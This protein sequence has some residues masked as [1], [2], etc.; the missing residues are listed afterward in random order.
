MEI[1]DV[2][3]IEIGSLRFN[4]DANAAMQGALKIT[5]I[6]ATSIISMYDVRIDRAIHPL[7]ISD[8]DYFKCSQLFINLTGDPGSDVLVTLKKLNKSIIKT[9]VLKYGNTGISISGS[10]T[11][12]QNILY[13]DGTE[14]GY[15][16]T[17]ID[18]KGAQL[19][20]RNGS[21][22]TSTAIG[23]KAEG[24]VIYDDQNNPITFNSMITLGDVGCANILQFRNYG[25][26]ATN[27]LLNMDANLHAIANQSDPIP[28]S[29]VRAS[30]N[31]GTFIKIC[32]T[33]STRRQSVAGL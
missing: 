29:M 12:L 6:P 8:G 30:S 28:N 21:G 3:S 24:N 15:M 20:L 16:E 33:N 7:A 14:L 27:T 25:I 23:I 17:G 13:L 10:S 22:I 26:L 18:A 31:S 11:F 5:G 4:Q 1:T 9:S 19:F 32:Y 2:Q